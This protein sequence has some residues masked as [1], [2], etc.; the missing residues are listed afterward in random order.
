MIPLIQFGLGIY[1]GKVQIRWQETVHGNEQRKVI[2][3]YDEFIAFL[4]ERIT[5]ANCT[6]DDLII[7]CSSSMDFPEEDTDDEK[8]IA[9]A[10]QIRTI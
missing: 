5:I 4:K 3:T 2:E 7:V 9:L 10:H 1:D 8:V 6:P